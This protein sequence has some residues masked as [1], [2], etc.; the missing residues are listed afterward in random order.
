MVAAFHGHEVDIA[1][2]RRRFSI[3][4]KGT[5]LRTMIDVAAAIGL[6]GR[7]IRCE[8]EELSDLRLPAILHWGMNHFVVLA[9]VRRDKI[10]IHDPAHGR[11]IVANSVVRE[12]FTGIALELT[13]NASFARIRERNPLKLGSLFSLNG[14]VSRALV[15]TG[16]ISL[17]VELLVLASPFYMQFVIDETLLRN[18]FG[19]LSVLAIA[20]AMLVLFRV[21]A[22]ALR[23]LTAQFISNVV[24]FDMKGRI[25]NHLVRLPFDWFQKRQVGDV[26]S[27]FWAV[28]AIQTFVSQGALT[29]IL[30]GLLGSLVLVMMFAYSPLLMAVVV[31]SIF[32]YALVRIITFKMMKRFAADAIF[33]DAREQTRFLETLRAMQTIKA[34][35]SENIRETQ[36]RN[37]AAASINSQI[38][39]GNINIG[40]LAAEQAI[41]G[42]THVLVIFLGAKAIMSGDLTLG[43]LTAFLAYK[44]QFVTRF[45]NMVEQLFAWRL[46]DIQLERLSDIVLTPKDQRIDFGGYDGPIAGRMECRS[47]SFRYAFGEPLVLSQLNLVIEP[48]ECVAIVGAS[49][50]GKSTLAKLLSGLHTPSGGEVLIDGRPLQDWSNRSL[51]SQISYVSQDDQLL[52]GSVA[53]NIAFFADE[54]DMDRVQQSAMTAC[55]HDEI[56]AMPMGY[57]SLVGDMGS[58]LSGGQKQRV[59]I[60]RALYRSP[61]IL[62]MDEATAHLDVSNEMAIANKLDALTI[63]RIV[64]AHRPET[65][66]AA[67]RVVMLG[68]P[69][70]LHLRQNSPQNTQ[71]VGSIHE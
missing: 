20:F 8:P 35:G 57:E 4:M 44:G 37:A 38:R 51:R 19:L 6:S 45:T 43:M 17:L 59:L 46:L 63:T 49:G 24:A 67:H 25:F 54:I 31:G 69:P 26:Q 60:A 68:A 42:F 30:D 12:K 1:T 9:S 52:A 7:P 53:E 21:L 58:S 28:R 5:T 10:M 50:C 34:A 32:A 3:S 18:D 27:R 47:L 15:Q 65:I 14:G 55:I 48:G 29:G 33:T 70:S 16:L 39:S 56:C 11:L 40:Y 61:R 62:I 36:Y 64:I 71:M 23:G 13:P 2:M 41:E 22:S 66:A